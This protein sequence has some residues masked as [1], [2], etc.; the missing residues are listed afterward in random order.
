M[1][2]GIDTYEVNERYTI[3]VCL[4]KEVGNVREHYKVL[5]YRLTEDL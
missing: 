2:I 5:G 3:L 4:D 1:K